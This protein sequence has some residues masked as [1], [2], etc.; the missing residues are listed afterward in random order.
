M[1]ALPALGWLDCIARSDAIDLGG[2][3]VYRGMKRFTVFRLEHRLADAAAAP[4]SRKAT[5]HE[6]PLP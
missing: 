4:T 3:L 1:D 5:T 6:H 2:A